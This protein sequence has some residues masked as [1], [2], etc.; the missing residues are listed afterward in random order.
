[1]AQLSNN[2]LQFL[3]Q[4]LQESIAVH[5]DHLAILKKEEGELW[6]MC[7][8]D[9]DSSSLDFADL[10]NIREHKRWVERRL[11]SLVKAQTEIKRAMTLG[12]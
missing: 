7:N 8:P 5:G 9:D 2:S 11:A 3:K 4:M 1:M 12:K 10:N 6:T